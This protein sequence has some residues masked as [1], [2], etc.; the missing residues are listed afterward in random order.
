VVEAIDHHLITGDIKPFK[1]Q[2]RNI[3]LHYS[4]FLRFHGRF[5]ELVQSIHLRFDKK[6]ESYLVRDFEES[7]SF[8]SNLQEL[9]LI[10]NS[11]S[12]LSSKTVKRITKSIRSKRFEKLTINGMFSFKRQLKKIL[13]LLKGSIK[14]IILESVTF[15]DQSFVNFLDYI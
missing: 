4:Q 11:D 12:L 15:N 5:L 7:L 1:V 2:L 10:V 3:R 14:G 8:A 6:T 9:S 13:S